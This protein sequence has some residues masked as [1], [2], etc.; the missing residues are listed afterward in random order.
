MLRH[1]AVFPASYS[2]HQWHLWRVHIW[3]QPSFVPLRTAGQPCN[4][5]TPL[6]AAIRLC[7]A[8]ITL[9]SLG[10]CHCV[11][12]AAWGAWP[13]PSLLAA[14]SW[15]AALCT[16]LNR[17]KGFML[18]LFKN[19]KMS[20]PM[21]S[22]CEGHWVPADVPQNSHTLPISCPR[23]PTCTP[24]ELSCVLLP[25]PSPSLLLLLH[26]FLLLLAWTWSNFAFRPEFVFLQV[27]FFYSCP[28]FPLLFLSSVMFAI[29]TNVLSFANAISVFT[30]FFL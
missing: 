21:L 3:E 11:T 5:V 24:R 6:L 12:R 23:A 7:S 9:L 19:A 22:A 30:S 18:S 15:I 20:F 29:A 26:F 17:D 27:K 8:F 4:P 1:L 2:L 28:Y 14:H 10:L 16:L 25:A 13:Q